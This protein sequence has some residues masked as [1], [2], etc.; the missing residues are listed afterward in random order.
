[1]PQTPPVRAPGA[2]P[3]TPDTEVEPMPSSAERLTSM[4]ASPLAQSVPQP[5][6]RVLARLE[7]KGAAAVPFDLVNPRHIIGRDASQA[8]RTTPRLP[9]RPDSFAS[10]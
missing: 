8:A 1:M 4:P 6:A 10:P 3:I 2:A 9:L 5:A 7:P